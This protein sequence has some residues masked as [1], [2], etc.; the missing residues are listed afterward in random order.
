MFITTPWN[1]WFQWFSVARERHAVNMWQIAV[2]VATNKKTCSPLVNKT[3][4][5]VDSECC[6]CLATLDLISP[7][8]LAW[9]LARWLSA[10][11]TV[12]YL[13]MKIFIYKPVELKN[14]FLGYCAITQMGSECS[15][16]IYVYVT[17]WIQYW[18][19]SKK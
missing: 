4:F 3:P 7:T 15:C 13:C 14:T 1:N 8:Y 5:F 2:S 6:F 19:N 10:V 11:I 17:H 18:H 9:G 16:Q 12:D